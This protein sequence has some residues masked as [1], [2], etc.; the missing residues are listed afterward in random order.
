MSIFRKLIGVVT[1][2]LTAAPV[3]PQNMAAFNPDNLQAITLDNASQIQALA[4]YGG[5]LFKDAE[6]SVDGSLLAISS[7]I[8]IQLYEGSSFTPLGWLI[9]HTGE[10]SNIAWTSSGLRLASTGEDASIRVWDVPNRTQELIIDV[11]EASRILNVKWSYDNTMLAAIV[12]DDEYYVS[13]TVW[14]AETG[15]EIFRIGHSPIG[16]ISWS[17]LA[18]QL[19]F[20]SDEG[21][22]VWDIVKQQHLFTLKE[23]YDPFW[24]PDGKVIV[25]K[26]MLEEDGEGLPDSGL[27][28]WDSVTGEPLHM[29]AGHDEI[30][31]LAWSPDS[32]QLASA[33]WYHGVRVSGTSTDAEVYHYEGHEGVVI[34]VAWSPDGRYLVSV[35]DSVN[36]DNTVRIWDVTTGEQIHVFQSGSEEIYT[37]SFSPDS[38]EVAA[39]GAMGSQVIDVYSGQPR[40]QINTFGTGIDWSTSGSQIVSV[41]GSDFPEVYDAASGRLL[42]TMQSSLPSY[43]WGHVVWSPDASKIAGGGD[44]GTIRIWDTGSGHEL[45][46]IKHSGWVTVDWSPDGTKLVSGARTS[47]GDNSVRIWNAATGEEI[48]VFTG[49]ENGIEDLVWSPD[50]S[51]IAT[52]S[53]DQTA[54]ILDGTTAKELQVFEGT[55]GGISWSPDA[56]MLVTGSPD[57]SM[58]VWDVLSARPIAHLKGPTNSY[59]I[60]WSPTNTL[61][62]TGGWDGAIRVWGVLSEG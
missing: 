13:I 49:H 14:S 20:N 30:Q 4:V 55:V 40:L 5:G 48:A 11:P 61:I 50:G 39:T 52:V 58:I 2:L 19:A 62:V 43:F 34:D 16:R 6:W 29:V 25:T 21:V 1:L 32:N 22:S 57:N 36:F 3:T 33:G 18:N 8:G 37:V 60:A 7:S 35:G 41:S 42:Q 15:K 23:A 38:N 28:L 10:V 53:S 56:T 12:Y 47:D 9:G 54:R 26:V 44:H 46:N 24:S 59:D 17:P 45:L 51:Q 27:Q 31:G